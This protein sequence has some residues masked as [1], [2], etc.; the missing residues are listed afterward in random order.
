MVTVVASR[1][2]EIMMLLKN[3][4]MARPV[5]CRFA[6]KVSQRLQKLIHGEYRLAV[7]VSFGVVKEAV[8]L[9]LEEHQFASTPRRLHLCLEVFGGR[10]GDQVV[11][12]S[13]EDDSR[14]CGFRDVVKR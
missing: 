4:W 11:F 3:G 12:R 1:W 10:N 7:V 6:L 13:E 2:V 5:D 14:R 8:R 9:A